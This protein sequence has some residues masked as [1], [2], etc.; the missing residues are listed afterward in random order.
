MILKYVVLSENL[1]NVK[2]KNRC[3]MYSNDEWMYSDMKKVKEICT[4]FYLWHGMPF[5]LNFNLQRFL[6]TLQ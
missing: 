1:L 5:Y 6:F 4:L 2:K 3:C